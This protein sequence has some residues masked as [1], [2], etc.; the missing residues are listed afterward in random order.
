VS[1]TPQ[2]APN[3]FPAE[4]ARRIRLVV[5]DVDGVLTDASVLVGGKPGEPGI[6]LKSF[7]IQ[8]GIG[9]KLLGMAGLAVAIVSGRY[10]EATTIRARELGIQDCL[11]DTQA[12]KL[13]MMEGLMQKHRVRW[14]EVAM[15]GDDIPDLPVFKKAGLPVAVGNATP[16]VLPWVLWRTRAT[17]GKGAVRE[18]CRE[19]LLARGQW[20]DV[21][22]RYVEERGG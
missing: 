8:D 18:F 21:V 12:Q 5:F 11:Q 14:E 20:E 22:R 1:R 6:E 19:F 16:E 13:Q 7:D 2:Q 15:V 17:G 3:A 9:M 10:S 4:Q